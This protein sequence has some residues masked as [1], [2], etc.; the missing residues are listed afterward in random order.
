[1]V[2][3]CTCRSI[4]VRSTFSSWILF[5]ET[6]ISFYVL[7]YV[8]MLIYS[9]KKCLKFFLLQVNTFYEFRYTEQMFLH[10]T[11]WWL[12]S[13]TYVVDGLF[14]ATFWWLVRATC[15]VDGRFLVPFGQLEGQCTVITVQFLYSGVILVWLSYSF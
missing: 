6:G 5:E 12:V 8:L 3:R 11:N 10:Q 2:R 15:M 9:T 14:L 1:M 4:S 7:Q 13:A